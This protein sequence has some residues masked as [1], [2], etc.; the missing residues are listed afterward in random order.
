M[1]QLLQPCLWG[2]ARLFTV[3]LIISLLDCQSE[4]QPRKIEVLFLGHQ[5][6][7][8][9]SEAYLPMLASALAKKGINFIYTDDVNALN[10]ANL[11]KYDGL[12]LYANHDS[13]TTGQEKSAVEFCEIREGLYSN[14]L[15]QLLLSQL[16]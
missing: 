16:A 13:I 2:I 6:E 14:P 4:T 7:H 10:E 9:N 5:S 12:A 1:N 3:F 15:R 8:H 11:Q